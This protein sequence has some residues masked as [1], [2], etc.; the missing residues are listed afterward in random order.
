MYLTLKTDG[1]L[2]TEKLLRG[3]MTFTVASA[4][5]KKSVVSLTFPA[6]RKR[7][8]PQVVQLKDSPDRYRNFTADI[9]VNKTRVDSLILS[10]NR[11]IRDNFKDIQVSGI[12]GIDEPLISIYN[13]QSIKVSTAINHKMQAI[14]ELAVPLKCL[15]EDLNGKFKY[16]IKMISLGTI[17]VP[18]AFDP[19]YLPGY[20]TT[21]PKYLYLNFTTDFWGEY[22]IALK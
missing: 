7:S 12:K 8:N 6:F 21:D 16:N 13:E 22:T 14:Y 1:L 4:V 17:A 3:G 5:K 10:C 20:I 2:S 15:G 11:Q 18:G 9:I 19:P